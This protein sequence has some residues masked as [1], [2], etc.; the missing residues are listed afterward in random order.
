M[1]L[2][3]DLRPHRSAL[4]P[5]SLI[6]A[7]IMRWILSVRS[8]QPQ[9]PRARRYSFIAAAEL[10]QLESSA[11]L[12]DNTSDL[13]LFGCHIKTQEPWPQAT[14]MRIRITHKGATFAAL[15]IVAH[16]QP[17]A[18]M[19]IAFTKIA[20]NDQAVLD[21]WIAALRDNRFAH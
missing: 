4:R 14:K 20:P 2:T 1:E 21:K 17:G 5:R 13:S 6:Y 8:A 11:Q 19:G 9:H 15:A 12:K 3:V 16:V 7:A 10:T 18:G